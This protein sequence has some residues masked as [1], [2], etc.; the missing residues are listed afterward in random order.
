MQPKITVMMTGGTIGSLTEGQS[1]DVN[2]GAKPLVD[3]IHATAEHF[4]CRVDVVEILNKLS[5][6]MTPGDWC[7]LTKSIKESITLGVNKFIVTHGTDTIAYTASAVAML[8]DTLGIRICFTGSYYPPDHAASDV[9][10]NLLTAFTSVLSEN[11]HE[12]VY[13]AFRSSNS[14]QQQ[15]VWSAFDVKPMMFDDTAFTGL[16]GKRIGAS[17]PNGGITVEQPRPSSFPK[18]TDQPIPSLKAASIVKGIAQLFVYPAMDPRLFRLDPSLLQAVILGLYHSGTA[19]LTDYK[20]SLIS[21]IKKHSS[22]IPIFLC[23]IPSPYITSFYPSTVRLAEAGGIV[24]KDI[25]PHHLYTFLYLG[26][27]QGRTM[28]DLI[29]LLQPW[30]HKFS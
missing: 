7:R 8:L 20:K 12:G 27:A 14:H 28:P 6:D 23:S 16:Y 11:V 4:G 17:L 5:E 13:V 25:M 2:R 21:F 30:I 1:V 24:C 26:L 22:N 29:K 3:Q 9:S 18:L 19:P 15:S 10:G